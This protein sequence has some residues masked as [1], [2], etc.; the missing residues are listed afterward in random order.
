MDLLNRKV[1]SLNLISEDF[2]STNLI[3][4]DYFSTNLINKFIREATYKTTSFASIDLL[5]PMVMQAQEF[6]YKDP[7]FPLLRT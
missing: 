3:S 5:N 6:L 1:E 4:K 2:L 7:F